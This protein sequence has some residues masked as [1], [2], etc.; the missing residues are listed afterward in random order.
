MPVASGDDVVVAHRFKA[1]RKTCCSR[2]QP[3][4]TPTTRRCDRAPRDHAGLPPAFAGQDRYRSGGG[5]RRF[6]GSRRR[7]TTMRRGPSASSRGRQG[8]PKGGDLYIARNLHAECALAK[9]LSKKGKRLST[10]NSSAALSATPVLG[11][12][13]GG[14]QIL[15]SRMGEGGRSSTLDF[16][17]WNDSSSIPATAHKKDGV[18]L[19]ANF[20]AFESR[21]RS[22]LASSQD[23]WGCHWRKGNED[24]HNLH[25]SSVERKG[26][27]S[28]S[29]LQFDGERKAAEGNQSKAKATHKRIETTHVLIE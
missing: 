9:I 29:G 13:R 26:S 19:G 3:C 2:L 6:T 17:Q 14:V 18:A 5:D 1:E 16:P 21:T 10:V 27:A 11:N 28:G 4:R 24:G 15:A 22:G 23:Q 8:V 20:A 7:T 25:D 12:A